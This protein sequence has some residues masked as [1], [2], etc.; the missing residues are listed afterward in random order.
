M[1]RKGY[2]KFENGVWII[3]NWSAGH[4]HWFTDALPRL[5]ASKNEND[6]LPI[7][8]PREFQQI[9][10]VTQSL[11][12]L[13]ENVFYY[14]IHKPLKVGDLL[15][16]SHTANTGNY[17]H[18]LICQLRE[19][20]LK[21]FS[22]TGNKKIY[23][24]RLKSARRK[25]ANETEVVGLLQSHGYEIHYFENYR[26]EKQVEIISQTKSLVSIHGSGLTNMIFMREGANV[27]ELR[28]N[29]DADNNC[30]YSLASVLNL[31]Y[32]Y[33]LNEAN[34]QDI[35]TVDLTVDVEE[36][37]KNIEGMQLS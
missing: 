21:N 3:D 25:I 23:I 6:N 27:L 15:V 17:N 19:R 35:K 12:L 29:N 37:K 5:V 22:L 28:N 2:Q 31:N 24:S 30:F 18:E 20:F 4:F 7:L 32:Y 11:E 9:S 10:Y 16:T 13:K 36:L 26:I 8:L 34:S 1:F 33:Q 14:N